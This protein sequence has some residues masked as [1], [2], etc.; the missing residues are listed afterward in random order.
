MSVDRRKFLKYLGAVGGAAVVAGALGYEALVAQRSAPSTPITS[1]TTSSMT[2]TT[3]ASTA[4]ASSAVGT[5]NYTSD[6]AEF[7]E[8]LA[9]A[10]KPFR[11]TTLNLSMESEPY[12]LGV[13]SR[14]PDFYQATGINDSYNIQP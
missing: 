1:T 4:S 2:S 13:Q 14:D 7:M 12:Y 9:D 11:G 8:W 5:S 6:Y 10:S 3:S